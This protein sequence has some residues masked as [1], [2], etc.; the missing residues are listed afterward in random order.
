MNYLGESLGF[1]NLTDA[2]GNAERQIK[3]S[4]LFDGSHKKIK[5]KGS[6]RNWSEGSLTLGL[7]VNQYNPWP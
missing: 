7:N 3:F 6:F 4:F 5:N 2:P 1:Q